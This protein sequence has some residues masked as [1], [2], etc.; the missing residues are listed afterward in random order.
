[1]KKEINAEENEKILKFSEEEKEGLFDVTQ[2][3]SGA[4]IVINPAGVVEFWEKRG[5]RNVGMPKG[6]YR[7]VRIRKGSIICES[8]KEDLNKVVRDK[9]LGDLNASAIWNEF[10]KGHYV[11]S[12]FIKAVEQIKGLKFNVSSA[13]NA[14]FF[15][16]NGVLEITPNSKNMIDYEDFDGYVFEEQIIDHELVLDDSIVGKSDFDKFLWNIS[17]Q[18]NQRYDYVSTCIGYLLHSHKDSALTK[19]VVL[20]DEELDF[21]GEANGGTGKSI[22]GKA[23]GKMTSTLM[24]DGKTLVKKGNRFFYQDL[25]LAHRVL[26]LDDV[27]PDFNFEDFYSVVTGD[28]TVEEKYKASYRIPFELSPKLLITS[29]YMVR[30]SGGNSD[31]RRRLEVEIYPHYNANYT[32]QDDFGKRLFDDWNVDEWNDFYNDMASYCQNFMKSGII[33][34]EPINLNENKLK[35]ATDISFV[36]FVDANIV[37]EDGKDEVVINKSTLYS[38][39]RSAYPV[40]SRNITNVQFKKWLDVWARHRKLEIFHYK[41]NSQSM[42]KFQKV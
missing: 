33:Q 23:V 39:F 12:G 28:M 4:K 37:F 20:V 13:Q 8:E 17:N 1:M 14:Y 9:L 41:S 25:N 5:F 24:K 30:G 29:N 26:F 36:E 38:I 19:A 34:S 32:P 42:V 11:N 15:F 40:E 18:E 22:I 27:Q 10:L 2:T 21:S 35:M 6:G 7:L 31:A 3:E 16:K